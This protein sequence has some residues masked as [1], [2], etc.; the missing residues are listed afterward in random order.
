MHIPIQPH[1][2]YCACQT[3]TLTLPCLSTL[4]KTTSKALTLLYFVKISSN[5]NSGS[6]QGK[7]AHLLLLFASVFKAGVLLGELHS[8]SMSEALI[9][10]SISGPEGL[11]QVTNLVFD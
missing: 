6:L 8:R 10:S 5:S 2:L 11:V 9:D 4:T 1:G 3:W 7:K